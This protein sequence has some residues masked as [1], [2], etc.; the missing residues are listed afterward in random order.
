[1]SEPTT[2]ATTASA[3]C[4][5]APAATEAQPPRD[6][7]PAPCCGTAQAAAEADACCAPAAKQEA[8]AVDAGCC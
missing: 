5:T 1:M 3:C 8:Q 7:A 6:A 4:G 2:T